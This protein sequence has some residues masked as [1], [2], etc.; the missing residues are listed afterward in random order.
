MNCF[1]ASIH[2]HTHHHVHRA[3]YTLMFFFY[4]NLVV[5]TCMYTFTIAC[6]ACKYQHLCVVYDNRST[7]AP[8]IVSMKSIHAHTHHHVYRALYTLLFFF[9]DKLV[10]PMCIYTFTVACMYAVH[11][12]SCIH[13]MFSVHASANISASSTT[14]DQCSVSC[15][16]AS[17]HA[18]THHHVHRT[19]YTLMFFFY[20]K[21]VVHMCIY[22]FTIACMYSLHTCSCIHSMFIVHASTNMS[23][24]STTTDRYSIN[25][26]HASIHVH[27]HH[28]VHRTLYT[29]L[30][31]VYLLFGILL[32][33]VPCLH[34]MLGSNGLSICLP[35]YNVPCLQIILGSNVLSMYLRFDCIYC[36]ISCLVLEKRH[37]L[38]CEKIYCS[39]TRLYK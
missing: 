8:S 10:V 35:T 9:Y 34:T 13:S 28:H 5:H 18:H 1:H 11:A 12:C 22:T 23:A 24:S 26:F 2:P 32:L 33:I 31:I 30:L 21:L 7:D 27:T 20:D 16:H 15:F 38:R 39:Q 17:I 4:D 25:C 37:Q 3:M 14:T 6:S 29:L 36:M 19:L